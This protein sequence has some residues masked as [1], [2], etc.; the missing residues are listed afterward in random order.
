MQSVVDDPAA[1]TGG[2]NAPSNR[3]RGENR[4]GLGDRV[5]ALIA[6]EA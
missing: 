1:E 5:R 6:P 2:M 4:V 3:E